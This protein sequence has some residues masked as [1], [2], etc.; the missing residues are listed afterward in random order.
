MLETEVD[1]G[2]EIAYDALD[3]T[4][5][6][7]SPP[8]KPRHEKN[9][10]NHNR[11]GAHKKHDKKK[12]NYWNPNRIVT[13][14]MLDQ[15]FTELESENAEYDLPK[16]NVKPNSNAQF[17]TSNS[18]IN[19]NI[20]KSDSKCVKKNKNKSV[21]N[22]YKEELYQKLV[23]LKFNEDSDSDLESHFIDELNSSLDRYISEPEE[24]ISSRNTIDSSYDSESLGD[25]N[26]N[27]NKNY[28]KYVNRTRSKHPSASTQSESSDAV[29]H[30]KTDDDKLEDLSDYYSLDNESQYLRDVEKILSDQSFFEKYQ[31]FSETDNEVIT[32]INFQLKALKKKLSTLHDKYLDNTVYTELQN[33]NR[34]DKYQPIERFLSEPDS[35]YLQSSEETENST[36]FHTRSCDSTARYNEL[37]IKANT[38]PFLPF[39]PGNSSTPKSSKSERSGSIRKTKTN[40]ANRKLLTQFNSDFPTS[41]RFHDSEEG[42]LPY[43]HSFSG[44]SSNLSSHNSIESSYNSENDDGGFLSDLQLAVND[45]K[46]KTSLSSIR[47]KLWFP[48]KGYEF[49]EEEILNRLKGKQKCTRSH[50]RSSD[51]KPKKRR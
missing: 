37:H 3:C 12:S 15:R 34:D 21:W 7:I 48:R 8:R 51:F 41:Y 31:L 26:N 35:G 42:H 14:E 16:R 5:P 25:S 6:N 4:G 11:N 2:V 49:K 46:L 44:I 20:T 23:G 33:L 1:P 13:K 24:S 18:V 19:C 10:K 9:R 36:S 29:S 43:N 40:G 32:F 45:V 17:E 39:I 38:L 28:F 47:R 50:S 27:L 22:A 30:N